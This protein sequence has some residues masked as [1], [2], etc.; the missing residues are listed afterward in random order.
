M[1][2]LK[3][4]IWSK[5]EEEVPMS[6]RSR[7]GIINEDGSIQSIYCHW[8]GYYDYNGVVLYDDYQTIEKI[9]QLINLGSISYLASEIEPNDG[10]RHTFDHPCDNVVVAYHRD[11]REKGCSI[12]YS[13]DLEDF[14]ELSYDSMAEY[15]YLYNQKES[16]WITADY[17][18]L[19]ESGFVKL[20]DKLKELE[21]IED[22]KVLLEMGGIKNG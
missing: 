22:Q 16:E 13:E 12:Q 10:D 9:K 1:K 14:L 6:T 17:R 20:E 7:I 11:R 8:N 21:L 18:Y 3:G 19:N 2:F 15:V 4:I 5:W